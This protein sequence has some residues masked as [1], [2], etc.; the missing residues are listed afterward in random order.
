MGMN[1]GSEEKVG[2]CCGK[3]C[4]PAAVFHAGGTEKNPG[5]TGIHRQLIVGSRINIILGQ[6]CMGIKEIHFISL[7]SSL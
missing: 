1:A 7:L 3:I 2:A 4:A 6:M 5:D